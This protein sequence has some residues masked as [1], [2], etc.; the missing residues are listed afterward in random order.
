MTTK[1][2]EAK[3]IRKTAD[4]LLSWVYDG[5]DKKI[6]VG[7]NHI[8]IMDQI[9]DW[10][11]KG[12]NNQIVCGWYVHD[13]GGVT[14][15]IATD[16]VESD[17]ANKYH[18][19]AEEAQKAAM[20]YWND[21]DLDETFGTD[22]EEYCEYCNQY[23]DPEYEAHYEDSCPECGE[24][25]CSGD[26]YEYNKHNDHP[27]CPECGEHVD[28]YDLETHNREYHFE[29]EPGMPKED[30]V[31]EY[32]G[33]QYFVHDVN[34]DGMELVPMMPGGMW[35]QFP[36]KGKIHV[37]WD[38]WKRYQKQQQGW[39]EINPEQ[40]TL[41]NPYPGWIEPKVI[42]GVP[43]T[44]P[45]YWNTPTGSIKHCVDLQDERVFA[46]LS[47]DYM[48]Q[49]D[50]VDWDM[51]PKQPD[52]TQDTSQQDEGAAIS[53]NPNALPNEIDFTPPAQDDPSA[54][55][56][57]PD[58]PRMLEIARDWESDEYR[59]S[60]DGT[61]LHMWRVFNRSAYGPSHYDMFGHEGY[62]SHSQ[63]RVYVSPGG[64][65]GMLYWQIT[66]PECERVCNEWSLKTFGKLPDYT[67]R[68]YGPYIGRPVSRWDFPIVEV[69]GLPLR[70]TERWWEQP[71]GYPG[72]QVQ[73]PDYPSKKKR[74]NAP[75]QN[76]PGPIDD[77]GNPITPGK[78]KRRK[79]TRNRKYR[80]RNFRGR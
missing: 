70:S 13:Y 53:Q 61:Q 8:H 75:F 51:P 78:S 27:Y 48:G 24:Y 33:K 50:D 73:K 7:Q 9:P 2:S 41:E 52:Y 29:P 35:P 45:S 63:G 76:I 18:E 60:Y 67:Y 77:S 15:R 49:Y 28:D 36:Y 34:Y 4:W 42:Q 30:S 47:Y 11:E 62:N 10:M 72:M 17:L 25:Y 69:G 56:S 59:W 20:K 80:N 44:P 21:N 3:K 43:T 16:T 66:H 5:A 79:R 12:M 14:T 58:D 38:D 19:L 6:Y 54:D 37:T 55:V 26:S 74:K 71:G 31:V 65:V 39:H 68:A 40:T 22:N 46:K 57:L 64:K 1:W 32:Q 23:Y